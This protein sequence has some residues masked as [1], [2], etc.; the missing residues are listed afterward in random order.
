MCGKMRK[1]GQY[2]VQYELP[3]SG[4]FRKNDVFL[5]INYRTCL[6]ISKQQ[7]S[8]NVWNVE[9]MRLCE[10]KVGQCVHCDYCKLYSRYYY[11]GFIYFLSFIQVIIIIVSYSFVDKEY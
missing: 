6:H 1:C 5:H 10:R 11:Y 8:A 7:R 9:E 4:K 2:R 3:N